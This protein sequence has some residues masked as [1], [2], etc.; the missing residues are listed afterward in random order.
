[1]ALKRNSEN[2][3]ACLTPP[4]LQHQDTVIVDSGCTGHF[5]LINDPCHNKTKSINPL[6]VRLPYGA[7]MNSIHTASLDIPELSATAAVAHVFPAMAND[8]LLSVEKLRN[9]G[10][11]V[12]LIIDKVTIFNKIGKEILKGLR[13]LDTGLWRINLRKEI[14]HNTIASANN[15]YELCYTGA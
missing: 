15:V 11:S 12:T 3:Q 5:L 7:T 2:V 6:Q 10:Y 1:M 14:Q 13:D 4:L 8:S 9:E